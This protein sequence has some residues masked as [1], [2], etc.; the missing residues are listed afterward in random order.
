LT[1]KLDDVGMVEAIS[2]DGATH[3]VNE[4][5]YHFSAGNEAGP[6]VFAPAA[7][8]KKLKLEH[9]SLDILEGPLLTFVHSTF[10]RQ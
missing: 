4:A 2:V 10:K 1:V 9:D 6:Y 5:F 7:E 8:G 3:G